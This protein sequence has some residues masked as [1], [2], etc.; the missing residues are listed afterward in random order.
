MKTVRTV[1]LDVETVLEA[2]QLKINIS[3]A[4]DEGLKRAVEREKKMREFEN[5]K[6]KGVG[7][8]TTPMSNQTPKR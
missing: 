1:S 2:R 4:C 3:G 7:G 6:N 8:Q 5:E